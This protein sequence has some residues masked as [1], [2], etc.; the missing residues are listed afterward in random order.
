MTIT[1]NGQSYELEAESATVSALL[2]HLDM[3]GPPVLVEVNGEAIFAR[4]FDAT[5]ISSGATIEIIRMVA[6]G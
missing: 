5:E 3:D 1:L 4:D 6:G 2:E